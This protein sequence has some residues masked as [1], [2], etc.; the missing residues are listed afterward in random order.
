VYPKGPPITPLVGGATTTASGRGQQELDLDGVVGKLDPGAGEDISALRYAAPFL[1][2]RIAVG[3]TE[4]VLVSGAQVGR[5]YFRVLQVDPFLG[6]TFGAEDVV[7]GAPPT[8]ILGYDVWRSRF[9]EDRGIVGRTVVM[10]GEPHTVIG[11][12][13]VG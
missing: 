9:G 7:P 1:G 2:G 5:D 6:R 12:L 11:V 3:A 10:D 8:V 4:P 13:P